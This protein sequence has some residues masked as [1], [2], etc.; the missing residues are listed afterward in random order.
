M[1]TILC[2][3]CRSAAGDGKHFGDTTQFECPN[4]GGYH[5]AG[6]VL[7]LIE[8]GT[9]NKLPT[10]QAFKELVAKKRGK[11]ENYPVITSYDLGW[12]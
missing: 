2:P 1:T 12:V 9:K 5:L 6:T 4:C 8:K 10:P 7:A 3:V 11:S